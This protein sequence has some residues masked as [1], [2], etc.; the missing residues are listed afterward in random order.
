MKLFLN[1]SIVNYLLMES[2]FQAQLAEFHYFPCY[3]GKGDFILIAGTSTVGKSSIVKGLKELEPDRFEED[4][5]LRRDPRDPTDPSMQFAM[6]DDAINHSLNGRSVIMHADQS[7]HFLEYLSTQN[8]ILPLRSVLI[9]CPFTELLKR[10]EDR[11]DQAQQQD[12]DIKNFRDPLVPLDQFSRIYTQK[13]SS[14]EALEL[15]TRSQ[16]I[17]AYNSQFDKM[18]AYARK[19]LHLLPTDEQIAIDKTLSLKEFLL[20]LG[21]NEKLEIVEIAPRHATH[22]DLIFN[23]DELNCIEIAGALHAETMI[24]LAE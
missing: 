14:E 10:L 3:V 20:N 11:N 13:Q 7:S 9:F 8:I 18:I 17:A 23:S 24:S 2:S 15:L 6:F 5:D 19:A 1:E 12:G 22:Y 4:L 16:V 21:F